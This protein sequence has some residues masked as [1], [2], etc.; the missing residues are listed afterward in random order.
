MPATHTARPL[1][2]VSLIFGHLV[3]VLVRCFLLSDVQSSNAA[4]WV[5]LVR[6]SFQ[7]YSVLWTTHFCQSV[8]DCIRWRGW[9]ENTN[10]SRVTA[11]FTGVYSDW[12]V[13]ATRRRNASPR[14]GN[15]PWL[16]SCFYFEGSP[17]MT[18]FMS[19][20]AETLNMS[21]PEKAERSA[22]NMFTRLTGSRV[23][24][25]QGFIKLE[26]FHDDFIWSSQKW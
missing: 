8:L 20:H 2:C 21:S 17:E 22:S 1:F 12:T 3:A 16:L 26:C 11:A 15:T 6:R 24:E 19:Q 13:K 5:P 23:A 14:C 4:G 7:A 9:W 18:F 10:L 25:F